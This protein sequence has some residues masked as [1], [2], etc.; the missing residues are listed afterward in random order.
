MEGKKFILCQTNQF[1]SGGNSMWGSRDSIGVSFGYNDNLLG[2]DYTFAVDLSQS[3][4][5]I[6]VDEISNGL[7]NVILNSSFDNG[8]YAWSESVGSNAGASFGPDD[9]SISFE[10]YFDNNINDTVHWVRM[11]TYQNATGAPFI[12]QTEVAIPDEQTFK[13][14]VSWTR[15]WGEGTNTGHGDVNHHPW[16]TSIPE[17]DLP[18][19][20]LGGIVKRLP[21]AVQPGFGLTVAPVEVEF[22]LAELQAAGYQA[23]DS[24]ELRLQMRDDVSGT[25]T[26]GYEYAFT[27]IELGGEKIPTQHFYITNP[28]ESTDCNLVFEN[29]TQEQG[30]EDFQK[31]VD[32][33]SGVGTVASQD[34][35][36]VRVEDLDLHS[37]LVW[38]HTS[39]V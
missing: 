31:L 32:A 4:L 9:F 12:S 2:A 13:C 23:G 33:S 19:V 7:D 3:N 34:V 25:N 37:N 10:D 16:G 26:N 29:V 21:R 17:A 20:S 6:Q 28:Y 38:G 1:K 8:N 11:R 18:A 14:V 30:F 5:S 36:F 39:W 35:S 27:N 15:A 22:T 24:V